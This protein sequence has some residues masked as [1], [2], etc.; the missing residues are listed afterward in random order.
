MFRAIFLVNADRLIGGG[1]TTAL[2][3]TYTH[4]SGEE[5][6]LTFLTDQ[7]AEADQRIAS[8]RTR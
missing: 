4:K 8:V 2:R 7:A 1:G 6:K 3:I 5:C